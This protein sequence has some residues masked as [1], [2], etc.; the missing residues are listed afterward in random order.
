M[1]DHPYDGWEWPEQS[2]W[3]FPTS[4]RKDSNNGGLGPKY[5][6]LNDIWALD[7]LFSALGPLGQHLVLVELEHAFKD[8]LSTD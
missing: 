1:S 7:T 5:Y 8:G 3:E 4:W 6:N 2:G